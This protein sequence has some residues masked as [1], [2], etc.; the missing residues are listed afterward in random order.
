MSCVSLLPE[1]LRCPQKR[2]RA[3][4]PSNYISPLI[5]K[6]RKITVRMYPIL[7]GAPDYR[8]RRGSNNQLLVELCSLVNNKVAISTRL[9]SIVSDNRAFLG[10]VLDMFGFAT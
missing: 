1:K 9:K 3:H 2:S 4:F 7:I 10:E 6:Q 8:F 5:D